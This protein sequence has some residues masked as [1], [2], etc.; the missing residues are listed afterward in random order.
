M[1]HLLK[2]YKRLLTK[3]GVNLQTTSLS[4]YRFALF[5]ISYLCYNKNSLDEKY[6]T[7]NIRLIFIF[8]LLNSWFKQK[9]TV[10]SLSLTRKIA[11]HTNNKEFL[12]TLIFFLLRLYLPSENIM[13]NLAFFLTELTWLY[14]NIILIWAVFTSVD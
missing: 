2:A 13:C 10:I 5:D 4:S 11:Y 9:C 12:A 6:L 1:N 14:I 7:L 8:S 3:S